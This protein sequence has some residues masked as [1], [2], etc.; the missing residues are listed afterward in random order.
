VGSSPT[1]FTME[2]RY[3]GSLGERIAEKCLRDKGYQILDRNY[4]FRLPG[5]P[6]KGEI[7]IVA[8][9]A[10]IISFVEVK[11]LR[12]T[13]FVWGKAFSPE[14]KVNFGKQRK[15]IK[16]AESWLMTKK[17]PLNS[18]WQIDVIS[19]MIKGRKARISH[20][21]NAIAYA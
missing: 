15:L 7:D 6:Q 20:F 5:S 18:K 19:V 12:L 4:C 11:T 10:D 21:E 14:V 8:K 1:G 9:K 3:I 13:S 16:T 17:I 2:T